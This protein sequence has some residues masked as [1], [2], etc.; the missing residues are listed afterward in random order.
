[1]PIGAWAHAQYWRYDQGGGGGG[2]GGHGARG[3]YVC[4]QTSTILPSAFGGLQA[5]WERIVWAVRV[6]RLIRLF[7]GD[8]RRDVLERVFALLEHPAYPQARAAVKQ[9]AG[10]L[11]FNKPS[12][13]GNL[14]HLLKQRPDL[15][16]NHWRHLYAMTLTEAAI[17]QDALSKPDLNALA[18][19]AYH[20]YALKPDRTVVCG[21]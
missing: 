16:E 5:W 10:T 11:G 7:A 8:E 2:G 9:V 21:S 18:E 14:H 15:A 4:W 1:M 20:G 6:F 17:G 3:G 13:W 19:L 12:E